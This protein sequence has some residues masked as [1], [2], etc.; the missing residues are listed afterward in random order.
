VGVPK[1][2]SAVT[3]DAA[4]QTAVATAHGAPR[5][6]GGKNAAHTVIVKEADDDELM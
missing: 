5:L 6:A 4:L 1:C 2:D 3:K